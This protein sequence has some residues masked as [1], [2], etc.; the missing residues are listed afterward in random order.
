MAARTPPAAASE[1][2][3]ERRPDHHRVPPRSPK[4]AARSGSTGSNNSLTNG[5]PTAP[6]DQLFGPQHY[7]SHGVTPT[8]ADTNHSKCTT[9]RSKPPERTAGTHSSKRNRRPG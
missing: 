6:R 5:Q 3:D 8:E 1:S 2:S 9:T 7:M 4:R